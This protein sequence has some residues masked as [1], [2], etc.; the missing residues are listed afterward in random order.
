M[1]SSGNE[2]WIFLINSVLEKIPRC[3]KVSRENA[4]GKEQQEDKK[5]D[6]AS[7]GAGL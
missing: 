6:A 1:M 3:F 2:R 5:G 7:V 4:K